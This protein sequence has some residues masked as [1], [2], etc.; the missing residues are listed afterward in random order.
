MTAPCSLTRW[1]ELLL[2]LIDDDSVQGHPRRA[3]FKKP[4]RKLEWA[5]QRRSVAYRLVHAYHDHTQEAVWNMMARALKIP[6]DAD[7]MLPMQFEAPLWRLVHEQPLHMLA[8][9]YPSWRDFLLAQLDATIVELE[10]KCGRLERCHVGLAQ[11]GAHPASDL[12]R[13]PVPGAL[14]RHALTR[15]AGRS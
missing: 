15:V 13:A 6:A 1:R 5:R 4:A 2:G 12:A 9:D 11:S 3:E 8:A 7:A 10:K 14:P